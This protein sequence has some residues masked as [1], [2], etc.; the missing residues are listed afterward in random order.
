MSAVGI[1]RPGTAQTGFFSSETSETVVGRLLAFLRL[2]Y[3]FRFST[4]VTSKLAFF[5]TAR[6]YTERLTAFFQKDDENLI[7]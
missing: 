6:R 7:K 2:R 4:P 3:V 1:F 5:R